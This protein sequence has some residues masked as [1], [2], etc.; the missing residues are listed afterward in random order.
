MVELGTTS[1]VVVK[2]VVD[3][4]NDPNTFFGDDRANEEEDDDGF[5]DDECESSSDWPGDP[6]ALVR[7]TSGAAVAGDEFNASG[8]AVRDDVMLRG[9]SRQP[10]CC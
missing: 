1:S 4:S 7:S 3:P 2:D 5:N 10:V 6:A 9:R 8:E